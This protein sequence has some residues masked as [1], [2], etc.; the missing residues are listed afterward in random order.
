MYHLYEGDGEDY[1]KDE[2]EHS[3]EEETAESHTAC[4]IQYQAGNAEAH[5]FEDGD[6]HQQPERARVERDQE[7]DEL[8]DRRK[9]EESVIEFRM[10]DRGRRIDTDLCLKKELWEQDKQPRNSC[11]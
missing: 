3:A 11:E 6:R 1:G 2:V 10:R 9:P 7:E 5:L 4:P 8:K